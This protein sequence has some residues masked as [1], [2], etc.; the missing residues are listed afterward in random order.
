MLNVFTVAFFGH[1]ILFDRL[2]LEKQLETHIQK[3]VEENAYVEF[4]VGRNGEFDILAS[5]V[6]RK[7]RKNRDE[8]NALILVL[9]YMTAEY[10]NNRKY[11]ESYYNEIEICNETAYIHPKAAIQTRNKKWLTEQTSLFRMSKIILEAHTKPL[12]TQK[13]KIKTL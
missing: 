9:P 7:I 3:I 6:V 10:N 8:N 5:T 2:N 1:R 13:A 12:N 11:F 4:L